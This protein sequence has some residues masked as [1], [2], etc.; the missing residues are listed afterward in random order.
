MSN[1]IGFLVK[2]GGNASM[3][4]ATRDALLRAMRAEKI[5]PALQV[6]LLRQGQAAVEVLLGAR[7]TMYAANQVVKPPMYCSNQ[8]VKP[9]MYCSNQVVKPPMYC[10]NQVVKPPKKASKRNN[11][12]AL[13]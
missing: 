9:P 8:V 12:T 11:G 7:E 10:S 6:A 1:V 13:S 2:A 3:R 5:A 4:H